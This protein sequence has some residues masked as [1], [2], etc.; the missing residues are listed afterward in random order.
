M[1]RR[2]FLGLAASAGALAQVKPPEESFTAAATRDQTP[3]VGVVSSAYQG[4]TDHFG[5]TE[6]GL[7]DP[8][9]IDA[10]LTA[11]QTAGML[12]LAIEFGSRRGRGLDAIRSNEWVV[13]LTDSSVEPDEDLLASLIDVLV[14]QRRGAR[15]SIAHR[16]S[17]EHRGARFKEG[18]ATYQRLCAGLQIRHPQVRIESIDLAAEDAVLMPLQGR[19]VAE[20]RPDRGYR[21]AAAVQQCDRLITVSSMKTDPAMGVSLSVGA[22]GA[23]AVDPKDS[24]ERNAFLADLYS[25]RPADYAIVGGSRGRDADGAIRHNVVVAGTDATGVDAVAAEIMGFEAIKIEHLT[26]LEWLGLGFPHTGAIWTR[27]QDIAAVRRAFRPSSAWSAY[28]S[29]E[30]GAG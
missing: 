11:E 1:T 16:I 6:P 12:R 8:Q 19:S 18:S 23:V 28:Q 20:G 2:G 25:L 24:G 14:E 3:R 4:G 29:T 26:H 9:P 30:G 15:I 13:V 5:N 10:E 27:G 21:I 22:Y 17:I 7:A